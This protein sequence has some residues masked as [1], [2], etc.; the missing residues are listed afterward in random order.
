MRVNDE[1]GHSLKVVA[2]LFALVRAQ[3]T[4]AQERDLVVWAQRRDEF[5]QLDIQLAQVLDPEVGHELVALRLVHIGDRAQI[6]KPLFFRA[7]A[8]RSTVA[9]TVEPLRQL[10]GLEVEAFALSF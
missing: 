8:E 2:F 9:H 4:V 10:A 6:V 5:G 3:K 7:G 1:V